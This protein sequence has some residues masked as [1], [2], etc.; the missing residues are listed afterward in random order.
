MLLYTLATT[1]P[2]LFYSAW[3]SLIDTAVMSTTVPNVVIISAYIK[4]I[5]Y[6]SV[7]Q[8]VLCPRKVQRL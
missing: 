3:P 1:V 4:I 8:L 5:L 2:S 7:V 6:G